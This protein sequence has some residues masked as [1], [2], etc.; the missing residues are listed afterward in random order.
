[1][2]IRCMV[3]ALFAAALA[4]PALSQ[5]TW[6]VS[7]QPL[8]VVRGM[9]LPESSCVD[10][11]TGMIYVSNIYGEPW[12]D[13]H[14]GFISQLAPDGSLKHWRWRTA[15]AQGPMSGPKGMVILN[16]WL[17][18]TDI[19]R[20]HAFC[21]TDDRSGTLTIAGAG[22]LNDATTDGTFIYASDTQNG[23]LVRIAAD[24][25]SYQV[26][27]AVASLNGL[28]FSGG[29]L[30]G[31]SWDL[32]DIFW[33]DKTGRYCAHALG[34]S[35]NFTNLDGIEAL[36]DGSFIVSDF[37]GNKVCLVEP[38]H[39]TVRTLVEI[40]TPADIGVDLQRGKL[41]I[42]QFWGKQL[43]VYGLGK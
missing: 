20:V 42:P 31:V 38:D 24:F 34:L 13:D 28:T 11:A 22:R 41:L 12:A 16:G 3:F 8:T 26:M 35:A 18:V 4:V 40:S 15:T 7:D 21:L 30:Y 32:H 29:E 37:W 23:K 43:T 10:P 27:D 39:R 9:R 14:V 2:K 36:P 5:G 19:Y 1:M 6:H 33:L 25:S 17:Y